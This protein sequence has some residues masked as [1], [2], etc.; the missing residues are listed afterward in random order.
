MQMKDSGDDVGSSRELNSKPPPKDPPLGYH[1]SVALFNF[2]SL[3]AEM[4][5]ERVRARLEVPSGV[6][7]Q[8][9]VADGICGVADDVVP[10]GQF[11]DDVFQA[12]TV[13]RYP[14]VCGPRRNRRQAAEAHVVVAHRLNVDAIRRF[15]PG[16]VRFDVCCLLRGGGLA[17]D[18]QPIY[19]GH[20]AIED[21]VGA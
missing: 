20:C 5:V 6:G 17:L 2:N 7:S 19:S 10:G 21:A 9:L 15:A 13:P 4:E 1:E 11:G 12:R 16:V 8:E 14:I 18:E 3:L